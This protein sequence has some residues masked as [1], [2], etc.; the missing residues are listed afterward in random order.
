MMTAFTT[1]GGLI[2]M[3]LGNAKMIGISYK[4][5]G[6]TIIGGMMFSTFVSLIAVPWAYLLFDDLRN[7]FKRIVGGILIKREKSAAELLPEA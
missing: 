4:P 5:L 3:A 1:I 2:P 6:I 7:Y